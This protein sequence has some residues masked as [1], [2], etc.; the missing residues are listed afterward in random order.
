MK[1]AG[2]RQKNE[3]SNFIA[4]KGQEASLSNVTGSLQN[5]IFLV[6][7]SP[8]F[9]LEA[10]SSFWHSRTA[11]ARVTQPISLFLFCPHSYLS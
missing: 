10:K 1:R 7:T 11:I 6:N 9:S 8:S 3:N 5:K 4:I 2:K